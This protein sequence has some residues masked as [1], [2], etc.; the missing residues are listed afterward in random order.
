MSS[1]SDTENH[2]MDNIALHHGD[3]LPI[4][5]LTTYNTFEVDQPFHIL[6]SEMEICSALEA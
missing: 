4:I 5:Q 6:K 1:G 3:F 2:E